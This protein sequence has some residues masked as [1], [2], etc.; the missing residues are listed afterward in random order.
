MSPMVRDL[1]QYT[2]SLGIHI[3]QRDRIRKGAAADGRVR[4]WEPLFRNV[5]AG[6]TS[7]SSSQVPPKADLHDFP[8]QRIDLP[9]EQLATLRF[10]P[11]NITQA[12]SV[13][14]RCTS[15]LGLSYS[16]T[17]ST[18]ADPSV[19]LPSLRSLL[20][21][22]LGTIILIAPHLERLTVERIAN[23]ADVPL[24]LR[25][26]CDLQFLGLRTNFLRAIHTDSLQY[27]LNAAPTV[28]EL[29]L[30]FHHPSGFQD[31]I[32]AFSHIRILPRLRHLHIH[33][34]QAVIILVPC[35]TCC[36]RDHSAL[37]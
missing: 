19:T 23:L 35:S 12:S 26:S 22:I 17:A 31:Q 14:Q 2:H 27:F 33:D 36:A 1:S 24:I 8:Y 7:A 29:Q 18:A 20:T 10:R 13:L 32:K 5:R 34:N 21:P 9:L 25:S 28:V 16:V 37:V 6:E 4:S 15:L 3:F 30:W 11:S